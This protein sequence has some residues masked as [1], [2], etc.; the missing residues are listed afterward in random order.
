M[1]WGKVIGA[2]VGLALFKGGPLGI[3]LGVVVGHWVD[4]R[5]AS[6]RGGLSALFKSDASNRQRVF[7]LSVVSLAAKLAKIDGPVTRDEVDAFKALFRI[8]RASMAGIA[9]LYDEAK[10]NPEDFERHAQA[11]ADAFPDESLLLGQV[12]EALRQIAL[13]DGPLNAQER[14]F[15]E[16]VAALFGL[17]GRGFADPSADPIAP[18]P[19][20]VLGVARDAPMAEIKTAWRRLTR[21]HHPDTLMAKGVPAEY[22]AMATTKM[23]TINAAWDSIRKER[24]EG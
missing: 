21:E 12:L 13:V 16:R 6:R 1:I 10:Q 15:L 14:R 8:P 17:M 7:S 2:M 11:L 23:A 18:D 5:R 3:V 19:Y 4:R 9:V 20:A 24:G 22:V